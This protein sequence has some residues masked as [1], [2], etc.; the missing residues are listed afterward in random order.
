M[1]TWKLIPSDVTKRQAQSQTR[2]LLKLK[3]PTVPGEDVYRIQRLG[4]CE[5]SHVKSVSGDWS[6]LGVSNVGYKIFNK[7]SWKFSSELVPVA[8]NYYEP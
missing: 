1:E 2:Q 5:E 6:P 3:S 7:L 4:Q 8:T